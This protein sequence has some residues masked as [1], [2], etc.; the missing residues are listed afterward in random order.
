MARMPGWTRHLFFML[1][2]A[3]P[4]ALLGSCGRSEA[5]TST[6]TASGKPKV[7]CT[8]A[9]VADLAARIGGDEVEV[10][11]LMGSGVDPHLF[12]PTRSD[13]ALLSGADLI[14]GNGLMLEG[15]M[16]ET[17]DRLEKSGKRVVRV[18]EA[19]GARD[20]R[21]LEIEHTRHPDPH[22]WMDPTLWA[23][24]AERMRDALIELKPASRDTFTSRAAEVSR[25]LAELHEYATKAFAS[26]PQQSRVLITAHDAFGYLGQRYGVEVR[27]IQGISTESEAG[28]RDLESLADLIAARKVR[29]VFVETTVSERTITALAKAARDKGQPVVIGGSLFSDAMGKPGTYEGTYVGM[30]DHNV[31]TIVRALGGEAPERGMRGSLAPALTSEPTST[32]APAAKGGT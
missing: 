7:V 19:V 32:P 22:V 10:V 16:G 27:G 18:G 23:E 28:L 20:R 13:I 26:I 12:K 30:I 29:A 9:M 31:T 4:L 24:A 1:V 14:L 15:K 5:G 2:A 11:A 8:V 6:P 25:D 17:F 21:E 3:L